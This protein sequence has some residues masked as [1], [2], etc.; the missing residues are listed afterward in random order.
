MPSIQ[1]AD[2]LDHNITVAGLLNKITTL[3]I[4]GTTTNC[5]DNTQLYNNIQLLDSLHDFGFGS[6]RGGNL[7]ADTIIKKGAKY[8]IYQLL[9]SFIKHYSFGDPQLGDPTIDLKYIS[10]FNILPALKPIT[11]CMND[12]EFYCLA[13]AISQMTP[14]N[15]TNSLMYIK[16]NKGEENLNTL[17]TIKTQIVSFFTSYIDDVNTGGTGKINIVMDTP[18]NI[19]KVL[20]SSSQ[21][22]SF[23]YILTQESAHDSASK[24]TTL[25]P[26]VINNA[27]MGNGFMEVF[28]TNTVEHITLKNLSKYTIRTYKGILTSDG[29]DEQFKGKY[30]INFTG[31]SY[32]PSPKET[33]SSRVF[34]NPYDSTSPASPRPGY[35][36][37]NLNK[38][39]H[40]TNVPEIKKDIQELFKNKKYN[41]VEVPIKKIGNIGKENIPYTDLNEKVK[42]MTEYGNFINFYFTKKRAGD[43]LQAKIVQRINNNPNFILPCFK[44]TI[45][46]GDA[47]GCSTKTVYS[48][49]K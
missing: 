36:D 42:T 11:R 22:N 38:K 1:T 13:N 5:G 34:Y 35:I 33:I 14:A 15:S 49:K 25:S 48:I 20:R 24:P 40:P 29:N 27:F 46:K 7:A 21:N 32:S 2:L 30:N 31:L 19:L 16:M 4:S 44:R 43:G 47:A 37:C 23:A 45:G 26:E 12:L 10:N 18:G 8:Y 39:P 6:E 28:N 9:V 17:S 41:S 3:N